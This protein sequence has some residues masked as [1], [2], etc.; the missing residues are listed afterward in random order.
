MD[1]GVEAQG[2]RCGWGYRWGTGRWRACGAMEGWK[3]GEGVG[4]RGA[5]WAAS[6]WRDQ[7]PLWD[8][9]SYLTIGKHNYVGQFMVKSAHGEAIAPLLVSPLQL[10]HKFKQ[11]NLPLFILLHVASLKRWWLVWHDHSRMSL[12]QSSLSTI[13]A[14]MRTCWYRAD[15][16]RDGRTGRAKLSRLSLVLLVIILECPIYLLCHLVSTSGPRF[17]SC[18]STNVFLQIRCW[19]RKNINMLCKK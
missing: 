18:C 4:G 13:T 14:E 3:K 10:C 16:W 19:F 2:W 5:G 1:Q 6:S 15:S 12:T 11:D 8:F 17:P 7:G 9:V